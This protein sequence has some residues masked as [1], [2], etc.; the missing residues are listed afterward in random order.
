[1]KMKKVRALKT[2]QV[3]VL[4]I[5]ITFLSSIPGMVCGEEAI[6]EEY[7]EM[8]AELG[9]EDSRSTINGD[10]IGISQDSCNPGPLLCIGCY[11][12]ICIGLYGYATMSSETCFLLA[13]CFGMSDCEALCFG[14]WP[15]IPF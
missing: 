2:T 4:L 3:I 11:E 12:Y 7:Q 10:I 13:F 14:L 5:V 8:K 1:M 6:S 9:C 15:E